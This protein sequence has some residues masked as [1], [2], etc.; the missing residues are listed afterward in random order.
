MRISITIAGS[1]RL[2]VSAAGAGALLTFSSRRSTARVK[3]TSLKGTALEP[4]RKGTDQRE[5]AER[6]KETK[7]AAHRPQQYLLLK[8]Y[9][10]E[11]S[12]VWG[13]KGISR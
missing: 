6:Q 12:I 5:G 11:T 3:D 8:A 4:G 7:K 9:D 2:K 1:Q 10:H 13:T